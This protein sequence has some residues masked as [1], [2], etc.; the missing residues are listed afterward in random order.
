MS[1]KYS[2]P[3]RLLLL[4]MV[5]LGVG[6]DQGPAIYR[7]YGTVTT[8]EGVPIPAGMVY[9][10]PDVKRTTPGVQGFAYIKNGK[11][12]TADD[13][14]GVSGGAY[15]ARVQGFDGQAQGE[16][17]LGQ[18]LSDE[19]QIPL[20]LPVGESEQKFTLRGLGE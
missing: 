18:P 15:L 16:L 9:F 7:V 5:G 2:L 17:P 1:A 19:E 11:F 12:D 3:L 4:C 20:D 10:D 13:G 6:C 8:T 14:R